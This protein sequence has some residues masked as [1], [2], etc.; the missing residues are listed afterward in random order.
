LKLP[1][2]LGRAAVALAPEDYQGFDWVIPLW[3]ERGLSGA[4]YIADKQD[5]GFYTQEEMDLAQASGERII[6][7]LAAEQMT[8]RLMQ[9]QRKRSAEN[10]VIDLRTRRKLHDEVLPSLHEV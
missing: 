10:S 1:D 7:L 6:D 3:A 9:I 2:H 8:K 5:R 4:L